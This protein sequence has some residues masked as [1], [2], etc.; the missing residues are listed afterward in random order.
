MFCHVICFQVSIFVQIYLYQILETVYLI[1]RLFQFAAKNIQ[2]DMLLQ[3]LSSNEK[4]QDMIYQ[5]L[6]CIATLDTLL[7]FTGINSLFS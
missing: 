5:E 1:M 7:T 4:G 2:T 3:L 6:P